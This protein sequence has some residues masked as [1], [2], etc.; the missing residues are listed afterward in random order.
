M[1]C[2]CLVLS[3][4]TFTSAQ[5][6]K[7]RDPKVPVSR[8]GNPNLTAPAPRASDRRPD[9]SGVWET[10]TV[11]LPDGVFAVEGP[12]Y[13]VSPHFVNV[14]ADMKPE[15]LQ[16]EPWAAAL[17]KERLQDSSLDPLGH[18]KPAGE[19]GQSEVPLPYK[20][21][22]TP[23]LLLVLYEENSVHRQIFLDGR[24]P[25]PDPEPRFY[26]Y[27]TGRWEGD[28]LVVETTGFNDQ[29][30]LDRMGHPHSQGMRM[31]E[32]FRRPNVGTLEVTVTIDDPKTYRTPITY[33]RRATLI[34]DEDLLEYFCTQNEKSSARYK[35]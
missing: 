14:T 13:R 26:G 29:H 25:V 35:K 31:T 28:T 18:C 33:T 15:Q 21:V 22:Q 17:F 32:R 5:W 1:L 2:V 27:S 8:D 23:T 9:L 24:K 3:S 19:P 34:A 4:A 6:A 10:N 16:M 11:A 20:I 12:G 7:Q 30:W